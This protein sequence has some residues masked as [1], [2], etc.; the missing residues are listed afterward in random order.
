[1]TKYVHGLPQVTIETDHK[2][3]I[4]IINYKP[5]VE[6]TP[7]IQRMRMRLLRYNLY[8][9]YVPGKELTDADALSRAQRSHTAY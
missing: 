1:M 3:L 4:P 9:E 2:P 6:M 5:L 7:G 8:A